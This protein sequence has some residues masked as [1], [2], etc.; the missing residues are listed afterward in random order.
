MKN[1]FKALLI[2]LIS[3]FIL[4]NTS[5]AEKKVYTVGVEALKYMPH[6]DNDNKEYIGFARDLLDMFAENQGYRFRYKVYQVKRLFSEFLNKTSLDLKYPD[7]SYWQGAMKKG[8]N[9]VYS[10]AV[11]EYIDG[12][13]VPPEFKGKG[14]SKLKKMGTVRGFTTWEYIDEIEKGEIKLMES[15][16]FTGLIK[17]VL[18][19][20]ING[21][22]FNVAVCNYQLKEV[23]KTPGALVFDDTLPHT[24]SNYFLSTIRYPKLINAFDDFLIKEKPAIDALKNKYQVNI[25]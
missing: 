13:M 17:Q 24:K 5:L 23:L 6:Y 10:Q 15:T 3:L 18:K 2:G 7:N 4:S 12:V 9:V 8:K 19:N 1:A 21:A 11:V 22:Y 20:R 14:I 25:Q 16:T